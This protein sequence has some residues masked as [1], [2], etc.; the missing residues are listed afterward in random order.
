[1]SS[2]PT[3]VLVHG[4]WA[5]SSSFRLVTT[6][7]LDA[8]HTVVNAPNLLHGLASDA[9]SVAAFINQHTTGDVVLVGHSY[10]GAVITN[11]AT[12]TPSVKALVYVDAYIPDEGESALA[13]TGAQPG[14]HLGVPP[15]TVFDFVQYPGAPEGDFESY[16]KVDKFPEIFAA[17]LPAAETA[18]LARSQRPV[19]LGALGT[20]SAAPAWNSIPSYVFIGL[21]D[22][23]IPAAQQKVMAARAGATVVEENAPHLSM[24]TNA[25][26][27]AQ[28]IQTA[29]AGVVA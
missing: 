23:V 2:A 22:N 5:D 11:A 6:A 28:L 21:D 15:E 8:G 4:A 18:L 12:S 17:D 7:L 27:I 14:S 10:G 9:A 16:I 20:P 25:S 13:L 29:A 26:T 24:L 19:T 1:M 3:I